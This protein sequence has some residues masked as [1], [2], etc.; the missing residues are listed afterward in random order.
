MLSGFVNGTIRGY[1]VKYL[2]A[3]GFGKFRGIT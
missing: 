1:D 3:I 2:D